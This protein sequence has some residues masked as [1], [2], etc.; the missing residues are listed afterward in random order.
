[1]SDGI[2]AAVDQVQPAGLQATIDCTRAQPQVPELRSRHH[3]VLATSELGEPPIWTT[4]TF[5][6]YL[7]VKVTLVFHEERMARRMR[8]ERA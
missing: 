7:V 6:T 3:P 8:R 5:A 4:V 2:D 1:M